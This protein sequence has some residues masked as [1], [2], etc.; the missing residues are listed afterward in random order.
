MNTGPVST[1]Y[2]SDDEL[3]A[4]QL[5]PRMK[6]L[7]PMHWSPLEVIKTAAAFLSD[8]PGSKIIDIGSGIGKFCIA[9][10]QEYPDC[11]FYGI[12]QR[13]DLHEI[14]LLSRKNS[15][16]ELNIHFMHGNFTELDFSRYDG[17]YFFN[18]FAEN[19]YSFG[20]IDNSIQYS[21]GLYN[22]YANY[23]YKILEDKAYGTR[24]V[25]Y[26]ANDAELP[27]NYQLIQTT[28]NDHL[29][30]YIKE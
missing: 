8:K 17:L 10:A 15:P 21:A 30:M 20:R 5:S 14:A 12:E 26:H 19:L 27:K 7:S 23:L 24:L 22:Y 29:K 4:S 1:A 18:S 2:Y 25:T 28:F 11:D 16:S 3:Y 9:A 6:K 13:K